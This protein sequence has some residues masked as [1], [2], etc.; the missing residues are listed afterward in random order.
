M[1]LE[2]FSFGKKEIAVIALVFVTTILWAS[3]LGLTGITVNDL[4]TFKIDIVAEKLMNLNTVLFFFALPLPIVAMASFSKRM[5]KA[6]LMIFSTISS[7]LGVLVAMFIFPNLQ[8]LLIIML[9]YLASVPLAIESA[10]MKKAELKS[11]IVPRTMLAS[12]GKTVMVLSIGFFVLSAVT[13]IPEQEQYM[14]KFE[15]LI[16]EFAG[17]ITS[18]NSQDTI[19]EEATDMF[20]ESQI[21]TV[22]LILNNQI[23]SKLKEKQDPDVMAFVILAD[24]AKDQLRS[25][26]YRQEI[27]SRFGQV[28]GNV[29]DKIDVMS[30]IK[31]Q[32]PFFDLVEKYLWLF[33]AFAIIGIFSLLANIICKPMAAVYGIILEFGISAFEPKENEKWQKELNK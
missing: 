5:D 21:A 17:E 24:G 28:S 3:V 32:F 12:M 30:I 20:V 9:A 4:F 27:E 25:E 31:K 15:G 26:E 29:V 23:Y 11:W 1:A 7:L 18:Q 19:T 2:N 13:M 14:E 22:D 16:Q 6:T 8:G 10:F 33:H